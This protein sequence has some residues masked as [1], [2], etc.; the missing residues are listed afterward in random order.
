[1]TSEALDGQLQ[2]EL[3]LNV[4]WKRNDFRLHLNRA[5]ELQ[6][7]VSVFREFQTAGAEHRNVRSAKWVLVVG[8][9]SSDVVEERRWSVDSW[10][11]IW[12]LRYVGDRVMAAGNISVSDWYMQNY[13]CSNSCGWVTG[14][15]WKCSRIAALSIICRNSVLLES[16]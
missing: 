14:K 15:M 10:G 11:Q 3:A 2:L 13:Q 9:C 7:K 1:M 4:W 6:Y 12:S 5:R 16:I 8:L